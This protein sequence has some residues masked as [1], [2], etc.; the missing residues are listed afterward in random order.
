MSNYHLDVERAL[1]PD[2][3]RSLRHEH[4]AHLQALS[5][6]YVPEIDPA[7]GF[8]ATPEYLD[9]LRTSWLL[10]NAADRLPH[11]VVESG[12]GYALGFL[13][14]DLLQMQWSTIRDNYGKTLSMV[15]IDA[16]GSTISV[17]PFSYVKKKEGVQNAEVFFDLFKLLSARLGRTWA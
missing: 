13:L 2:E 16:A 10:D 8:P 6:R 3:I 12:L 15:C 17:P 1:T 14:A 5:A 4:F 7:M 11:S 9:A